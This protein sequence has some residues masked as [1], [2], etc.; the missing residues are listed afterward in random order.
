MI[1]SII[2]RP[3]T[4]ITLESLQTLSDFQL[5][6]GHFLSHPTKCSKYGHVVHAYHEKMTDVNIAVEMMADT[7]QNHLDT[8][9]LL[10]AD[11]DL[12]GSINT[13]Q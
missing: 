4:P 10:S 9:L 11:S 5:Y 1:A 13:I 8:A 2:V 7:F 12:V 6:Y 3:D